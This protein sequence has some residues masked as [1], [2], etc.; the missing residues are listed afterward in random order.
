MSV[1]Q[2]KKYCLTFAGAVGSS[3]TPI[4]NFLS[5]KLNLPIFSNDA[6]RSEVIEDLGKLDQ[7]GY[8][9]RRNDRLTAIA[10]SGMAFIYDASV[11]RE[12][13]DLKMHLV[14][15]GYDWYIISLDLSKKLLKRL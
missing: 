10:K 15:Y 1:N 4:A 9:K 8:I 2:H 12:W 7:E 3:K 11:D 13:M 5:T 14:D 6:I